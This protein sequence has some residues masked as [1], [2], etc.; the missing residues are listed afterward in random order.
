MD[1]M[2]IQYTSKNMGIAI[3]WGS[4]A[5]CQVMPFKN[6]RR[7]F[8][9]SLDRKAF[10][11]CYLRVSSEKKQGVKL[12]IGRAKLLRKVIMKHKWDYYALSR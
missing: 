5:S 11:K 4:E 7:A 3:Y 1:A 2:R 12:Q 9:R 8:S 10:L 6:S